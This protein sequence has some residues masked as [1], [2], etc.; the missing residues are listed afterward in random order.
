MN[1][2][3]YVKGT[4]PK[5]RA[6]GHICHYHS[7]HYPGRFPPAPFPSRYP[8]PCSD[9]VTSNAF[10]LTVE[11]HINRVTQHELFCTWHLSLNIVSAQLS[12]SGPTA[13]GCASL[14]GVRPF[15]G[16]PVPSSIPPLTGISVALRVW[17]LQIKLFAMLSSLWRREPSQT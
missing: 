12:F 5:F 11:L 2:A 7:N 17:L 15:S 6:Q 3:R 9:S 14:R 4:N 10:C 16:M 1:T 8:L 13:A